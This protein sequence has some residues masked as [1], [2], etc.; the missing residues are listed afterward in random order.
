M[1]LVLSSPRPAAPRLAAWGALICVG[2]A[3]G[4]TQILGK[5]AASTGH[6]SVSLAF[7]QTILGSAFFLAV[8]RLTGRRLPLTRRHLTFY[9]VCGLTGTALPHAVSYLTIRH[10]P[11]G[12]Q[13][14]VFATIPMAT[15]AIAALAGQERPT[16]RRVL[17]LGMG[18][19]GVAALVGPQASLPGPDDA[20][21][22]LLLLAAVASYSFEAVYVARARPADL[23]PV[24]VMAGLTL[25]ALALL[26]PAAAVGGVWAPPA[27]F[28]AAEAA[29]AAAAMLHVMAY[30]GLVWLIGVAGPVFASQLSYVVTATGVLSGMVLLGERHGPW[31][32]A[33]LA[34]MAAGLTL[35]R[36]AGARG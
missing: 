25:G 20:F 8:M 5:T 22:A 12:V 23:D 26:A 13:S 27:S 28:G 10:L 3:W 33:A 30:L 9:A 34:L 7:W 21:W 1:T 2:L 31:V 14:I 6:A 36:P 15:L 4:F 18:F 29:L 35:V 32:W 11:V 17:G 19:L 16:L 24:Q